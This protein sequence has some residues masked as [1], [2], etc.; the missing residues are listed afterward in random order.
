MLILKI[1]GGRSVAARVEALWNRISQWYSVLQPPDQFTHLSV[2]SF[3]DASKPF[4]HYPKLK[5]KGSDINGH[6]Q[7]CGRVWSE[8]SDVSNP[9]HMLID[10]GF[11]QLIRVQ[12]IIN[13]YAKDLFVP[14]PDVLIMQ[15]IVRE[16]LRVYT[17][18]GHSADRQKLNLFNITYKFNVL[19]QFA[20]RAQYL[21][22]A[23]EFASQTRIMLA[24]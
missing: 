9:D 22:L 14:P 24:R 20:E 5:S 2:A 21:S 8:L 17:E 1:L 16:F 23:V 11:Q 10:I 13:E 3:C 19:F 18:L 4:A 6:V 15:Y 12:S 7:P